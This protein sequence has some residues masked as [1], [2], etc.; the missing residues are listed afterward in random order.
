MAASDPAPAPIARLATHDVAAALARAWRL[1]GHGAPEALDAF[2]EAWRAADAQRNHSAAA[3]AAAAA[4]CLIDG[5]YRDFRPFA[6]W[7]SRLAGATAHPHGRDE[8]AVRLAVLGARALRALHA[9][10]DFDGEGTVR[11][12]VSMLREATDAD[13]ALCGAAALILW[14]ETARRDRDAAQ[15]EVEADRFAVAASPWF[16]AHWASVR[17]QHALFSHR[18][19]EAEAK[20]RQARDIAHRFDLRSITVV[21]TLMEARLAVA[22]GDFDAARARLAELEPV[23]DEREPMWRAVTEQ[24]RS[25]AELCSG[26]FDYALGTARRA[27]AFA[28]RA[29]APDDES[30]QMR[31]LEGYCLAA[32][33]DGNGAATAFRDAAGRATP[34]QSRQAMLLADIAAADALIAA[35]RRADARPL[36]GRAL[37][38]ARSVDYPAFF[39]PVPDVAARVCAL[40]L[41]SGIETDYVRSLIR[42]RGLPPPA[43]APG[44]WPWKCRIH[45]LGGFRVEQDGKRLTTD[46]ARA[47]S[48]PM[49]LLRAVVALGGQRV[50]ADRLVAL[51]WPGEGRVGAR[52]AFNVTLLRLRRLLRADN[53]LVLFE[54]EVSLDHRHVAV[55]RWN[56]EAAL[57]A[58]EAAGDDAVAAALT[59]VVDSYGGPLLPDE[60]ASWIEAERRKLRLRVDAVLAKGTSRMSRLEAASLLSRALAADHELP[61]AA[62]ALR[63]I[64]SGDDHR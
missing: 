42:E 28:D 51:L 63:T 26:H 9:V 48:K 27:L 29:A 57:A 54:G 5:N 52:T 18:L 40:A 53:L 47:S 12:A 64:V 22:R 36:V 58:A 17:G 34:V 39:W 24:L 61:L 13:K 3:E 8:P 56:L 49:E 10:D 2:D 59:G 16:A 50:G 38:E 44:S 15:I 43:N 7:A 45:V 21:A 4:V 46:N 14:L 30:I 33:N 62:A 41:E 31:C 11:N 60:N 19:D 35:G 25:L 23:D 55:D 37:A 20:F 32:V 6:T 1:A